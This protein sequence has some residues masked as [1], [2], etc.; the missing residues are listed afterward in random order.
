[1]IAFVEGKVDQMD[2]TFVIL[3]VG[4]IGYEIKI[5]LAT[6]SV[7]KQQEKCKLYTHFHVKED[8]QSLYGFHDLAEKQVFLHL[9]SISGVGPNTAL[10]IQSSLG[11]KEIRHAI[12]QED[13]KSIQ[14]VKGIGLKTAQRIILELKDKFRKEGISSDNANFAPLQSNSIRD[15]A[16]TALVTLGIP[17]ATAEKNINKIINQSGEGISL[18]GLIKQ[19]LKG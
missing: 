17:R 4:G 5:S 11:S 8:A 15:E 10:M 3:D 14:A 16:L 6:Y 18:E 9:I 7:V 19:A 1:M 12:I 13:V 2:P